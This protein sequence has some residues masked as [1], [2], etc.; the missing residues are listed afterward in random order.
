MKLN[1]LKKKN[2]INFE[3]FEADKLS[4]DFFRKIHSCTVSDANKY[5]L[6]HCLELN[7]IAECFQMNEDLFKYGKKKLQEDSLLQN[8]QYEQIEQ[9][10]ITNKEFSANK[11]TS[12]SRDIAKKYY[13]G[14]SRLYKQ[15]SKR[16]EF[17]VDCE[18]II[19]ENK[20]LYKNNDKAYVLGGVTCG[21]WAVVALA[22]RC[23]IYSGNVKD[24]YDEIYDFESLKLKDDYAQ[25]L[26]YESS[27]TMENYF[28]N[29][30]I[31]ISKQD[32][33]DKLTQTHLTNQNALANYLG[34]DNAEQMQQL[35]DDGV[36]TLSKSQ[37]IDL[38]KDKLNINMKMIANDNGFASVEE[39][40]E[41][42]D[43]NVIYHPSRRVYTY[44]TWR[45]MPGYYEYKTTKAEQVF[46]E[47]KELES[48]YNYEMNHLPLRKGETIDTIANP[49]LSV[50]NDK[51]NTL[52]NDYMSEL[53]KIQNDSDFPKFDYSSDVVKSAVDSYDV[54]NDTISSKVTDLA[55]A[56]VDF[57]CNPVLD[58]AVPAVSFSCLVFALK[59]AKNIRVNKKIR[60]LNKVFSYINEN[61]TNKDEK[62]I[63]DKESQKEM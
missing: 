50:A 63:N 54:F 21:L 39:M 29:F 15:F 58:F 18:K 60:E 44:P 34:F 59:M 17:L 9:L 62:V 35:I 38:L 32:A 25:S 7:F 43:N 3:F 41:Y 51:M 6:E 27:E 30:L 52:E 49:T 10:V 45:V 11:F 13:A 56:D 2:N 37:Y 28:N 22:Y 4:K 16:K 14:Y 57:E 5:I 26:G 20:K 61:K 36:K 1:K 33:I 55:K 31:E 42:L 48:N 8:F 12:Y 46:N 47:K 19:D 53:E 40:E 23:A 24:R